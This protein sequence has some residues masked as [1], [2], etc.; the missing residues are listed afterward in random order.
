[1]LRKFNDQTHHDDNR[2]LLPHPGLLINNSHR[3][4]DELLNKLKNEPINE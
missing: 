1:M 3:A 2:R 4:K